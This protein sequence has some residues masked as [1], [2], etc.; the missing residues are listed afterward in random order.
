M[1][2]PSLKDFAAAFDRAA[3]DFLA[4]RGITT[5]EGFN[6]Q[7]ENCPIHGPACVRVTYG[8]LRDHF[9]MNRSDPADVAVA[10]LSTMLPADAGDTVTETL[11]VARMSVES[12]PVNSH[13]IAPSSRQYA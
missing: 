11:H 8:V 5:I 7:L 12:A 3:R 1:K 10:L 6:L 4:A 13:V 2:H 9:S